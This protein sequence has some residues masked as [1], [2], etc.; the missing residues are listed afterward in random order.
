MYD[1]IDNVEVLRVI[2]YFQPC[3]DG[4]LFIDQNHMT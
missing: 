4:K 1:T 3:D 2:K